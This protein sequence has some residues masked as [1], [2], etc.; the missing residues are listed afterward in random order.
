MAKIQKCFLIEKLLE[1]NWFESEKEAYPWILAG[2][3][4]V[5]DK[6]VLS[7]KE[8]IPSDGVIR[9]KE[10]Y[11]KKYVNKGGLKLQGALSDFN[12]DI[13]DKIALDCGASTGG[14]TDCLIQHGAKLVYAVDAGFGQLAGK[15]ALD[16]KVI[17][18]ERTNLSDSC[19]TE[20]NPKPE[21]IT[22]DLS[23]LSLKTGLLICEN[24][25]RENGIII[26]L[27]KPIYEVE[28]SEIRRSGNINDSGILTEILTD[29]CRYCREHGFDILGVTYSPVR[30]NNDTLEYFICVSHGNNEHNINYDYATQI[31]SAV[32]KSFTLEKFKKNNFSN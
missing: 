27:V 7:G 11:K 18:M 13:T 15:L 24:I 19:L 1:E 16:A 26:A 32:E 8:K 28:S 23:N 12:V 9:I 14:F 4:L 29:L 6:R 17:N 31:T 2:K 10:Y 3:V 21:V 20:L 30:G 5:N 22:L 25:L